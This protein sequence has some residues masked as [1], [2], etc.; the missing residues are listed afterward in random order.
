MGARPHLDGAAEPPQPDDKDVS[1]WHRGRAVN[2]NPRRHVLYW[3]RG[4]TTN[5]PVED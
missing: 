2:D 3:V 1:E 5:E 4:G